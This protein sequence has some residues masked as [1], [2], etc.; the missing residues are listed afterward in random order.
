MTSDDDELFE[1]PYSVLGYK[2]R[3]D[4]PDKQQALIPTMDK[5][6]FLPSSDDEAVEYDFEAA[7][8]KIDHVVEKKKREFKLKRAHRD[9]VKELNAAEFGK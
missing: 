2:A 5:P 3:L 9:A 1:L 4:G 8:D 7:L 6:S